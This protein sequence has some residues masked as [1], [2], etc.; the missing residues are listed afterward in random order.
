MA[1][2]FNFYNNLSNDN[3]GGSGGGAGSSINTGGTSTYTPNVAP[4]QL[5]DGEYLV[6]VK[7]NISDAKI[8]F[9]GDDKGS[10]PNYFRF[11]LS[12]L[13]E[14]GGAATIKLDKTNYSSKEEYRVNITNNPEFRFERTESI[15]DPS[16]SINGYNRDG[17]FDIN[18]RIGLANLNQPVF[19]NVS[20]FVVSI[21]KF[22]NGVEDSTFASNTNTNGNQFTIVNNNI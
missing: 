7:S 10:T 15:F 18:S 21:K 19:T 9:A 13:R 4:S 17:L 1:E 6:E 20:P 14:K 16:T 12:E 5:Q 22:V 3:Y 2:N 8:L 11:T